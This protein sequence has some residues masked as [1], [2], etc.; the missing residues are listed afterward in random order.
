MRL[1]RTIAGAQGGRVFANMGAAFGVNDELA[2]QIVRYFL[3]PMIKSITKRMESS[4]GLI[5]FLDF[6]GTRRHDRYLADPGIF[7]HPQVEADGRAIL[8]TLFPNA[9]HLRKIIENRAKVLPVTP[10]VLEKMLPYIA[11]L[12]LGAIEL[13]T[14]QPLRSILHRISQ[15][16]ADQV[17]MS[18]PYRA[19]AGEV[20]RHRMTSHARQH[21]RRSSL[22]E[23][24]GALFSRTD[25]QRAA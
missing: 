4:Q 11:I 10:Q 3:P 15:G 1:F 21:T 17:A 24:I 7:G 2:A 23:V 25:T 22:T 18:N 9:T 6:V 20:R 12:A 13:K 14:R 19:L 8:A 5:N 16:R